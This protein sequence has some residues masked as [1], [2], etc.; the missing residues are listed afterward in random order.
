M[1]PLLRPSPPTASPLGF[2][3]QGLIRLPGSFWRSGL[4]AA[5]TGLGG[6]LLSA[7]DQPT[8]ATDADR[9]RLQAEIDALKGRLEKLEDRR[10][11]A[12][13]AA[14]GAAPAAAPD[15]G[16]GA[17]GLG[18]RVQ[19]SLRIGAYGEMFG[20]SV[21]NPDDGG[22]R[23]LSFDAAR[24]VLLPT[25]QISDNIVFN[26][27]VEFEHGG[28]GNDDDDKIYGTAEIEQAYIDVRFNEHLSWRAPGVDVVPFGYTN[29]FHEPVL[30]YS[31]QRPELANGLIPTTWY[32]GSTSIYGAIVDGLNYQFQVGPG[33]EDAAGHDQFAGNDSRTLSNSGPYQPGISGTPD[34]LGFAQAPRGAN[35]LTNAL[36]YALRLSYQLA[37][38]LAGSSSAYYTSNVVPRGAFRADNS[39]ILG[40]CSVTMLDS[41]M[42]Y[43]IPAIGVELRAEAVGVRFSH[44]ENLRANN[45]GDPTDNVGRSMWGY[46][47]EAAYHWAAQKGVDVVPFYRYSRI[48]FQT[49]GYR[50]TDPDAPTGAG[51]VQ[52]HSA[53]VAVFPTPEVVFKLTYQH[54][55]DR[56]QSGARSDSILGGVGFFF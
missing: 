50:G 39:A 12:A 34:G 51:N 3:P 45:D 43:R 44:P 22:Q 53:G 27:E 11:G 36:G 8:P 13:G 23:Q 28:I 21:Q 6:A 1:L 26:A 19:D 17:F 7:A 29:L 48:D 25:F 46:S 40:N 42:R 16:K 15:G 54:V 49:S 37:Q 20:G 14:P 41:E 55:I 5:M 4:L 33:L 56:S 9:D 47:A 31:V 10:G 52:Y 2:R 35:Q 38:G 30:F 18:Y 32:G 24:I